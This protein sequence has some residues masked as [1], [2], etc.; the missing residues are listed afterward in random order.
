LVTLAR[1][2]IMCTFGKTRDTPLGPKV[3]CLLLEKDPSLI[4]TL[5][6][7]EGVFGKGGGMNA[8]CPYNGDDSACK[9]LPHLKKSREPGKRK[10]KARA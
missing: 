10:P 4:Q 7:L 8:R 6:Q 9:L 5:V 2:A 3:F 1:E